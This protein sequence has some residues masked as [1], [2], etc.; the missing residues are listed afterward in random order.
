MGSS[1]RLQLKRPTGWFAAGVEFE[2]ALSLLSD[3]SFKLFVCLCL[4]ARRDQGIL[5]ISPV[6]LARR[7]NRD[8]HAIGRHLD[9]LERSGVCRLSGFHPAT[10]QVSGRIEITEA[11][12]PYH[13]QPPGFPPS[14]P[15]HTFL[16]QVRRLLQAQACIRSSFSGAEQALARRWFERGLTLEQVQQAIWLGCARKYVAWSNCPQQA[17]IATLYYFEPILEELRQTPVPPTYFWYL[18]RKIQS[19]E[20]PWIEY[21]RRLPS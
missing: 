6:E 16:G 19:L 2:Q 5:F 17:P 20:K 13:R 10:P 1:F 15:A 7:L 3:A 18:R 12:W 11:F 4:R 21:H 14:D 9:E 8:L